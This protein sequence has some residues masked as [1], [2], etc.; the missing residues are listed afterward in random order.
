MDALERADALKTLTEVCC[1]EVF[2]DVQRRCLDLINDQNPH[3]KKTALIGILKLKKK[4][5]L[6]F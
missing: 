2:D 5:P 6:V 3:V 4:L 1:E